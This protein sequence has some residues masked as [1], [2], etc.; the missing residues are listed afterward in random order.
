MFVLVGGVNHRTAPVEV[1]ECLS[2]TGQSLPEA[3]ARIGADPAIAGCVIL[4]TCNRTEIYAAA[5][6]LDEA[7]N[8]IRGHLSRL[9]RVDIAG[10]KNYTYVHTLHD[11]VRH[12]F[13]VAAGL[14]SM[15]LGE[16]QILGQVRDAYQFAF[17]RGFTDKVL[18]T[19]FQ[20]AIAAGKRVRRATGIDQNAVSISYAAVDLARQALGELAG[21]S[22]LIIGAGKMSELAAR[23]LVANGVT[24]VIVSNRSYERAVNLARQFGGR[25]VKFDQLYNYMLEADIVISCTAAAHYVVHYPQVA[26]VMAR[27][28]GARLLLIDIAV[29]RDID[30]RIGELPGIVLRDIDDL[31]T[32]VDQNLAWRKQAAVTAEG[33]IEEE[34]NQFMAWL[35]IQSVVPT[36]TALK[37]RAEQIKKNELRRALNRLG[38]LSAHDK[39]VIGSLANSIVNQLLHPPITRLKE[40]ALTSEGHLYTE[41]LQNLFD[42]EVPEK[43]EEQ[44]KK[45]GLGIRG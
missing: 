35:G 3:L 27:R 41:V 5:R 21:R 7:L 15:L 19:L 43:R 6:E 36:I 33:I 34:L 18:N 44:A 10:I 32:V 45:Q 31:Q 8:A 37:E 23:Y 42:L 29:P 12:L 17:Q 26:E 25:A 40:Y 39:K 1:R 38:E 9:S 2:F 28:P 24:G 14:D 16:P 4:F 11:A 30:P 22:V 20:Q 13:R